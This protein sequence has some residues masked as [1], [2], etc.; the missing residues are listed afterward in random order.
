[1]QITNGYTAYDSE[2]E[3]LGFVFPRAAIVH[4]G[5]ASTGF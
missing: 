3:R 2:K 4:E 5:A 1:V